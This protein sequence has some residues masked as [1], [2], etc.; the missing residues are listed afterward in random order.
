MELEYLYHRSN[1]NLTTVC[2]INGYHT[3][4]AFNMNGSYLQVAEGTKHL[5]HLWDLCSNEIVVRSADLEHGRSLG[6]ESISAV[7]LKTLSS[8]LSTIL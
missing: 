4:I 3:F 8:I 1:V 5:P 7:S 2:S 6:S